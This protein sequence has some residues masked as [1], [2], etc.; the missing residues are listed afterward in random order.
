MWDC[1]ILFFVFKQKTAYEMRISD[2]S[3]D[4]CSSDLPARDVQTHRARPINS[5]Y[6]YAT[7]KRQPGRSGGGAFGP[8]YGRLIYGPEALQAKPC[9]ERA[10]GVIRVQVM[11]SYLQTRTIDR[12]RMRQVITREGHWAATPPV[13][14]AGLHSLSTSNNH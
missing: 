2:W 5:L 9:T 14:R 13:D 3:S 12:K 11:H 6:P 10:G 7:R 1:V 8:R 4:V